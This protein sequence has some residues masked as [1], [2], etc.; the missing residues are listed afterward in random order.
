M[1]SRLFQEK[2]Q[3]LLFQ[4]F[5]S[6]GNDDIRSFSAGQIIVDRSVDLREFVSEVHFKE[7]EGLRKVV[8]YKL[9]RRS[10]IEREYVIEC[11]RHR[12]RL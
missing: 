6:I 1:V 3:G 11:H 9:D 5:S 8:V 10:N 7:A 2:I 12:H 4:R